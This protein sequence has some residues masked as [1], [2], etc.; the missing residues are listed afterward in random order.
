MWRIVM[1]SVSIYSIISEKM[2]SM[3]VLPYYKYRF[4]SETH[5]INN[6]LKII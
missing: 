2:V 4:K 1:C 6:K 5:C 3:I